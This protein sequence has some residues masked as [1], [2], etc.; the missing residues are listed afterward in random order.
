MKG[1]KTNSKDPPI[2]VEGK[3]PRRGQ[4]L[5]GALLSSWDNGDNRG[6][7]KEQHHLNVGIVN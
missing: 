7:A 1:N 2:N 6:A 4:R 5:H 3:L